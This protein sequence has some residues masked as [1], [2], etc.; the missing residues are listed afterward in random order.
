[1]EKWSDTDF[2]Y[3]YKIDPGPLVS[4]RDLVYYEGWRKDPSTGVVV[5]VSASLPEY[6][7]RVP[8]PKGWTRGQIYLHY[9]RFTPVDG[10]KSTFYET[11]QQA[12]V[13]KVVVYRS[14]FCL[15]SE[16]RDAACSCV[17]TCVLIV[18]IR[19]GGLLPG[20]MVFWGVIRGLRIE[21][22]GFGQLMRSTP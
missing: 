16:L 5:N 1:M 11:L 3:A 14:R 8:L 7:A 22:D 6:E 18:Q 12:S 4:K 15:V 9:K 10:G 17:C 13:W 2:L 21:F 20:P 19:L